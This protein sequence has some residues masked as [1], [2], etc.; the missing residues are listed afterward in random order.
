MEPVE[1]CEGPAGWGGVIDEVECSIDGAYYVR[2][3]G[4]GER[5]RERERER[6]GGP[7]IMPAAS[8]MPPTLGDKRIEINGMTDVMTGVRGGGRGPSHGE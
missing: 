1:G 2:F 3:E 4:G 8:A 7:G 6:R 5:E